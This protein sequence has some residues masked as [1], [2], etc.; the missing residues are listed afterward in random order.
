MPSVTE[1]PVRGYAHCVNPHCAGSTQ[2]EVDAICTRTARMYR[3]VDPH[4]G[5]G[6]ENSW[7]AFRFA[8]EDDRACPGC[9]RPREVTN[10][11][12]PVYDPLSAGLMGAPAGG[13]DQD[14]LL[15][16]PKFSESADPRV[17]AMQAELAELRELVK[18]RVQQNKDGS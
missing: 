5:P 12:R 10:Q 11:K 13:F 8:D 1:T 15:K 16:V 3:D 18:G 6:E 9:G 2:Q 7:E 4:A 14:G 17:E